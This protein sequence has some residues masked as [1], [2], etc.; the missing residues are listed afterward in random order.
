[1]KY[2]WIQSTVE[3]TKT[4]GPQYR[5]EKGVYT[6]KL[7]NR[8]LN[9]EPSRTIKNWSDDYEMVAWLLRT[10]NCKVKR[11]KKI[12]SYSFELL[13]MDPRK[14]ETNYILLFH[15]H[16]NVINFWLSFDQ[17]TIP[18]RICHLQQS[19]IIEEENTEAKEESCWLVNNIVL[20]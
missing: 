12:Q 2:N 3:S 8:G 4:K 20:W 15:N 11:P 1:M 16:F 9:K 18:F 5:A 7:F 6:G 14:R 13:Y 19:K 10:C 17:S